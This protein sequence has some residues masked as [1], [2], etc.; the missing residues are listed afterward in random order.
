MAKLIGTGANQVPTNAD[1]GK[2]AYQDAIANGTGTAGQL[3]Q[4]GGATGSPAWATISTGADT[5]TFPNFASPNNTYTSSGTWS[6][7]SL[8]DDDFVWVYLVGGGGGGSYGPGQYSSAK[9]GLGGGAILLYGKAKYFDGGAYVIGAGG[10]AGTSSS[11]NQTPRSNSTFTL[12]STYGSRVYTTQ[13]EDGAGGWLQ[14]VNGT[15]VLDAVSGISVNNNSSNVFY[16]AG[17]PTGYGNTS[18]PYKWVDGSIGKGSGSNQVTVRYT[19]NNYFG[20][21][22]GGSYDWGNLGTGSS[23]WAGNGSGYNSG[24][25]AATVPGGGGGGSTSGNA[26]S[27]GGAGN[28]RVYHV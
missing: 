10:A 11:P 19:N 6:K 28:M 23:V 16:I 13:T 8:N 20:G 2:L 26:A 14:E 4:S 7:G 9:G 22:G 5:V 24:G 27:A 21:G 18:Y 25:G 17:P 12:T 1:L 3:L 15:S